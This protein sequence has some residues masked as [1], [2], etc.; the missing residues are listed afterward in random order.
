MLKSESI[1]ELASALCKAQSVM[2]FAKKDAANPFFKSKYAD[3]SAVVDAI[4]KPLADNGLAY[5]QA[6]DI[7]E[8]GGVIVETT[9]LHSSGQW[10][11]S[12]LRMMPVKADPQGIGSCITYARRYGLQAL[13]GIPADDDDGNAASGNETNAAKKGNGAIKPTDGGLESFQAAHGDEAVQFLKETAAELV[14]LVETENSPA[15]ALNH[16]DEAKLDNDE[17]LALWAIL[18]PNSKTR[19]AIKKE[20][21][22]RKQEA[23]QP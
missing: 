2:T 18:A 11:G 12:R 13:V 4:K 1:N 19:N 21:E 10:I 17:K 5:A 7:D 6:T 23:I 15:T 20:S 9:L 8:H 14:Q 3:L 22:R 16:L